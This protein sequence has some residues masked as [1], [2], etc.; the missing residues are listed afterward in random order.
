MTVTVQFV[1]AGR[2]ELGLIVIVDVPES[3]TLKLWLLPGAGHSIVNELVVTS[4]DSLKL[5]TGF[6]F[7]ATWSAP[8]AGDVLV[9]LGGAS[10]SFWIVAFAW[11]CASVAFEGFERLTKNVSSGSPTVSP[12]TRTVIV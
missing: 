3:L 12:I 8:S 7:T 1:A 5:I 11:P 9:T 4:T 6:V 2:S 10:S